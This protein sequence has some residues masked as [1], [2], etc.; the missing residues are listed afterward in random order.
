LFAYTTLFRSLEDATG[1]R[2]RERKIAGPLRHAEAIV[3]VVDVQEL[4]GRELERPRQIVDGEAFAGALGVGA[5]VG[6]VLRRDLERSEAHARALRSLVGARGRDERR[7]DR[8]RPFVEHGRAR[9][10][11]DVDPAPPRARDLREVFPR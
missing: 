7:E 8:T 6:H 1:V 10:D 2:G 5:E 11:A 4:S 3:E 9:A